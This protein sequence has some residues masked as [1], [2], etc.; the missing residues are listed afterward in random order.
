[1]CIHIYIYRTTPAATGVLVLLLVVVVVVVAVV[2]SCE[3]NTPPKTC[4]TISF[5][6]TKSGAGEQFLLPDCSG[7]ARTKGMLSSQRPVWPQTGGSCG[8]G[9]GAG[10]AAPENRM[11]R[12]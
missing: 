5:P 12:P 4:G 6:S 1:M 2:L 11:R 9:G 3:Q 8:R 7:T 10:R